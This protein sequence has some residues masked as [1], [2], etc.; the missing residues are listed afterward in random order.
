MR[1]E[2]TAKRPQPLVIKNSSDD[3]SWPEIPPQPLPPPLSPLPEGRRPTTKTTCHD[4]LKR[5]RDAWYW[6]ARLVTG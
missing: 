6:L 1:P 2:P 4:C 5:M 3:T